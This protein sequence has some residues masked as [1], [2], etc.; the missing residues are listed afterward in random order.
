MILKIPVFVGCDM[1][2]L[3][4]RKPRTIDYH[5][6]DGLGGVPD[7]SAPTDD[8]LQTEHAV[9]TLVRLSKEYKG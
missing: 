2:L 4:D 9:Q 7:H 1:P 8:K 5:G 3:G 6:A